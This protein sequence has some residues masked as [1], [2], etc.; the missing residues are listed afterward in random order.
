MHKI[1]SITGEE[2]PLGRM[3]MAQKGPHSGSWWRLD[4]LTETAGRHLVTVSRLVSRLGRHRMVAPPEHFGLMVQQVVTFFRHLKN[5]CVRVWHK[6]DDGIILGALALVPL[7][8]FEKYHLADTITAL[9]GFG[10][11]H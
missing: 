6:L 9:L 2:I 11:G 1:T 8:F 3:V 4:G 10:G 7:A 5:T